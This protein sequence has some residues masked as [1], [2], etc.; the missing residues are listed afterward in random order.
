MEI[1]EILEIFG[2]VENISTDFSFSSALL[3]LKRVRNAG[4]S[5]CTFSNIATTT[6]YIK[7][8]GLLISESCRCCPA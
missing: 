8:Q 1:L 4:F 6:V 7:E 5:K 2:A 3:L